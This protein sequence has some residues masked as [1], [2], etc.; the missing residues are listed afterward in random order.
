MA[1]D[2]PKE[3]LWKALNDGGSYTKSFEEFDSQ[4]STPEK[5]SSLYSSLNSSGFYTKGEE[6]FNNQF[7]AGSGLGK[8]T[9]VSDSSST[10]T[11]ETSVEPSQTTELPGDQ[12][13][14]PSG[15]TS[16]QSLAGN[17]RAA[18]RVADEYGLERGESYEL[19]EL[20]GY[21]TIVGAT[22]AEGV[23]LNPVR[24]NQETGEQA[25][26]I[27]PIELAPTQEEA[28][29]QNAA[30]AESEL[31]AGDKALNSI[32][33]MWTHIQGLPAKTAVL[34]DQNARFDASRYLAYFGAA[35]IAGKNPD[36][37]R[38]EAYAELDRLNE[39]YRPTSGIIESVRNGDIAGLASG[40]VNATTSLLSSMA[41]GLPTAGAGT[42]IDIVGDSVHSYNTTKAEGLGISTDELLESGRGDDIVPYITGS[43]ASGLE[44]IGYT[45]VAQAINRNLTGPAARKLG[46]IAFDSGKEAATEWTQ[47]GISAY[48]EVIASG[49]SHLEA[50]DAA[51][52][53]MASEEGIENALQGLFGSLSASG[54]G[55]AIR[56]VV[57][58]SAKD[59]ASRANQEI[60]EIAQDYV[61]NP[62]PAIRKVL[63]DAAMDVSDSML[64][65]TN[66][67]KK[68]L[69]SLP[70][71]TRESV[72]DAQSQIDT[73]DQSLE[74]GSLSETTTAVLETRR[75]NLE[76]E[77][78]Q[79]IEQNENTEIDS[80]VTVEDTAVSPVQEQTEST[81]GLE[82]ET[83]ETISDDGSQDQEVSAQ[84]SEVISEPVSDDVVVETQTPISEEIVEPATDSTQIRQ[85][86][87]VQEDSIQEDEQAPVRTEVVEESP[88]SAEMP[89]RAQTNP[90]LKELIQAVPR[91]DVEA[92]RG[93]ANVEARQDVI[94]S[95]TGTR[96]TRRDAGITNVNQ[97]LNDYFGLS[98]TSSAAERSS[99]IRNW[100]NFEQTEFSSPDEAVRYQA[101]NTTD[102][103]TVLELYDQEALVYDE[104][105][106]VISDYL[107]TSRVNLRD[108]QSYGDRNN[109]SRDI[110]RNRI[111]RNNDGIPLDVAAQE[112]SN[113]VGYEIT[114]NDI[115]DFVT[116]YPTQQSFI[117]SGRTENQG[118]LENRYRELTG[119]NITPAVMNRFARRRADA[120]T[121]ADLI[122]QDA[123][124]IELGVTPENVADQTQMEASEG[125]SPVQAPLPKS[126]LKGISDRL[127]LTGLAKSVK[128]M[129]SKEIESDLS[130]RGLVQFQTDSL[131][132]S[133]IESDA[134]G[135]G[136]W[137]KAPNGKKS[138]LNE[139]QWVLVRTKAF[140]DWFGDWENNHEN[141]SKVIDTNGEPMVVYHGTNGNFTVFDPSKMGV[142]AN[143]EGPGF[144]F[145]NDKNTAE[146]YQNTNKDNPNLFEVFLN[147]KNPINLNESNF[148]KQ[149]IKRI[150]KSVINNETA[151]DP[152]GI[153]D[154][155]DSF[156]SN[157]VDT[158]STTESKAIDEVAD[159]LV[160]DDTKIDF[161]A[162]LGNAVGSQSLVL[163]SV[164][165]ALG[166]DATIADG[167]GG[168]GEGG[169]SIFVTW[170][171]NQIKS[172]TD[173]TGG[174]DG[175][176]PDIRFQGQNSGNVVNGYVDAEGNIVVNSE[177]A[178]LDTLIHEFSHV[179]EQTIEKENPELHA[180]GMELIQTEEGNPYVDHVRSTQPGLE[181]SALY[182]EALA[183]AIGDSGARLVSSQQ[184]SVIKEWLKAAWDYIATRAGISGMT[185]DQVSRLS[186]RD[187]TDAVAVDLLS[188]KPYVRLAN[189]DIVADLGVDS[190]A[191]MNERQQFMSD[192]ILRM[193]KKNGV[194]FQGEVDGSLS[195]QD[196]YDLITFFQ[197]ARESGQLDGIQDARDIA[198]SMG[199]NSPAE[200]DMAYK[201][202]RAQGENATGFKKDEV[203]AE[204]LKTADFARMS[205]TEYR[206]MG[207]QLVES[208][209]VVPNTLVGNIID[210]PRALQPWEVTALQYYRT[211]IDSEMTDLSSMIE[212]GSESEINNYTYELGTD[213]S[214]TGYKAL[215]AQ[216]D[217]LN[218]R[219]FDLEVAMLATAN[220][221]SAAF[222]LRSLMSDKDFNVV[223]YL[224]EMKAIGYMNPDLEARLVQ[225]S[226]E[227]NEVRA[228]L[229][230]REGA[231]D[232]EIENIGQSNIVTDS[233]RP[234]RRRRVANKK[235][236]VTAVNTV[237]DSID[238][239]SFGLSGMNFQTNGVVRF[240]IEPNSAVS[241]AVSDSIARMKDN[242]S[243]NR[244]NVSD[245]IEQAIQDIDA[246]VGA[247]NWDSMKFRSN[248]AN[249][250]VQQSIPVKVKKPYVN[251]EGGLVVPGEYIKDLVRNGA[252]TIDALVEATSA[253]LGGA[254]GEYDIRNAIS[255]YGRQSGSKRS[256]LDR[257]VSRAK[258][259]ARLMSQIDDLETKGKRLKTF[260]QKHDNDTEIK[261]L[262]D[263]VKQLE[264]DLEMTP[265]E[266]DQLAELK[267]NQARQKYLRNYVDQVQERIDNRDFAPVAHKNRYEED[268]ETKALRT[269]AERIKN[270]F[271]K[272]KY[273]HELENRSDVEKWG[274]LAYEVVFNS[275]RAASAGADLSAIGVQGAIFSFSRPRDAWRIFKSGAREMMTDVQ[276][277]R[278]FT[279]LQADPY[280]EVARKAGLNLQLPSFYQS[281]QEEQYKGD[282]ASEVVDR[283]IINPAAWVVAKARGTDTEVAREIARDK[284][285]PFRLAERNY[286]LVL[287]QI[288]MNLFREFLA[289][290]VN[291]R[292][293]DVKIDADVIKQV[294]NE[295]NTVTMSSSVPL[296][297]SRTG[298]KVLSAIFF[299]ARKMV[300]TW[301][302]LGGGAHLLIGPNRNPQ[303]FKDAYGSVVGRGLGVMLLTTVLPTAIG[304]MLKY[305]GDD[306]EEDDPYFYNP[307]LFNPKHSDFMK[308]R[309]G[310]TRISLFQGIDGNA[311]F[312]TRF[313]T[314]EYMTTTSKAVRQL[315]GQGPNKSRGGLLWDYVRNKFAP[316]TSMGVGYFL[317]S[318]RESQET[319]DRFSESFVPMW[320]SGIREQYDKTQNFYETSAFAVMGI[321]GLSYNNYGGAE[322]ANFEG[323]GNRK[324]QSIFDK[325]GLSAYN[326]ANSQRNYFDGE[327]IVSASGRVYRDE[328]LPAYQEFMTEAVLSNESKLDPSV[329]WE[330]KEGLVNQ[331]KSEAYK[332]AE[333]KTSGVYATTTLFA[334][335]SEDG[336]QYRLLKSQYPLKVDYINQYMNRQ[337]KRDRGS[338]VR[339]VS[340]K[341]RSDGVKG[342]D[343][344][345]DILVDMYLYKEAN[346][347]ANDML[348]RDARRGKIDLVKQ[349]E[350]YSDLEN[351]DE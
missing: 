70:E 5:I 293:I 107:G 246:A 59:K 288:R 194:S 258:R 137:M 57:G 255:G 323:T 294:A 58:K 81:E 127:K 318:D 142:N 86:N 23:L 52:R 327:E 14:Q 89:P 1:Q 330:I 275:T 144:Y 173:N 347:Y 200:V 271:K 147:I 290:Q 266:R 185:A 160:E 208:G 340:R 77:I 172:A 285:N 220:Q 39:E 230:G 63:V 18:N 241:Q 162:G 324:A 42:V 36:Q 53:M 105:A 223:S 249:Q 170:E 46:L 68:T 48:E 320:A 221:Q 108:Y 260:K 161:I 282:F 193:K 346:R 209:Q 33:N 95:I 216:T 202:S 218:R 83:T 192:F 24:V 38:N 304:G 154:F 179:W 61:N 292:G 106:R 268:A 151:F 274:D 224:A 336:T 256:D 222:R 64:E 263:T 72:M 22:D 303:L 101:E 169:G 286:S 298:S 27:Q 289:N 121:D 30:I 178:G 211:Q 76:T 332:Y 123:N 176:N 29:A 104:R 295:V 272:E 242:I 112:L 297:Q 262:Q 299:S 145:T 118:V 96:P 228:K 12:P 3:K 188:G 314:G 120:V 119:R 310:D 16:G 71:A 329:N 128:F 198:A 111:S 291:K 116:E 229:R 225:L 306:E 335:F 316:T 155:R 93:P 182:K 51:G 175:T 238:V 245:A 11:S 62:D 312:L 141:S 136:S 109:I 207:R 351:E 279:E 165:E 88:A 44:R 34:L 343:A 124:M 251:S 311:V 210:S 80:E 98:E 313:I 204:T 94:E 139:K 28:E 37:V 163:K 130:S 31:T 257:K 308:I 342:T 334:K 307:N 25:N 117:D 55:R 168:R 319:V 259:V 102:P 239:N 196:L 100:A 4:F 219:L 217:L 309:L 248:I 277:E 250:L 337:A 110:S 301:K 234:V 167:Y 189:N 26:V 345:K 148:K 84:Q 149:E 190:S 90:R 97:S 40:I 8:S 213:D 56:G 9:E 315:N 78:E 60:T 129:S 85:A 159:M 2:N 333:I 261:D 156:M 236:T 201:L 302:I 114:P 75:D 65:A 267:Y 103:D 13:S 43:I 265:E 344:Y 305:M 338:A 66:E 233:E 243:N 45:G 235:E 212:R 92:L 158:Y 125:L 300:S 153:P 296:G 143:A 349:S 135:N 166:Y 146:G 252:E 171:S 237:L 152:E 73:I 199:I 203:S 205:D 253:E 269:E 177:I 35:Q 264:Y 215:A 283:V 122:Q 180:R 133:K 184:R 348:V 191:E 326:P 232:A 321:T 17:I 131:E 339:E 113:Q 74:G 244:L 138:N 47:S 270:E 322:F 164:K 87:E 206:D 150:I 19:D 214:I 197:Y 278:Y 69:D 350:Y 10:A 134:K 50:A 227:L 7:F 99:L 67:S 41:I 181:G 140:K 280:Y 281:V 276:Y 32:A 183:Q 187:F 341:L 126:L 21:D 49:G 231:V 273:R 54:G 6:E 174:F 325:S 82:S 115:V 240:Q 226:N 287:S 15:P 331:L 157:F 328:Y 284:T 186:L 91:Q 195:P 247:G 254:Y 79:T 317:G 132:L 20:P